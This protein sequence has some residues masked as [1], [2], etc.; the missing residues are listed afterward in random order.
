MEDMFVKEILQKASQI[1]TENKNEYVTVE[2]ILYT[3]VDYPDIAKVLKEVEVDK[4]K[5]KVDLSHFMKSKIPVVKERIKPIESVGVVKLFTYVMYLSQSLMK[6]VDTVLIFTALCSFKDTFAYYYLSKHGFSDEKVSKFTPALPAHRQ[7]YVVDMIE[8]AK[9][10]KYDKFIGR[11]KELSQ[12]MQTLAKVRKK[13]VLLVSEA[14]CGKTALIEGFAQMLAKGDVPDYLKNVGLYSLN[15]AAVVANTKM[16]G[17]L[18]ERINGI[19][20]EVVSRK[21]ILFIDELQAV[22]GANT[23]SNPFDISSVLKPYL[24]GGN[25]RCI[26][27]TTYEDYKSISKDRAFVRRFQKLELAE[28]TYDEALQILKGIV[29]AYE[30]HYSMKYDE[31]CLLSA[32]NLTQK[33]ITDRFLPDKAIDL[34]DEVGAD[35]FKNKRK[36]TVRVEDV[37]RVLSNM[38]RVPL[39]KVTTDDLD[40][41][42]NL[43][44]N[45]KEKIFGQDN[46]IDEVVKLIK[47]SK[48]GLTGKNKPIMSLV[49]AGTSGSG[50]TEL[51]RQLA[52]NLG[53]NLL[54]FDMSEY[55]EKHSVAK[56][57]GSPPGYVAYDEGG[58]LVSAVV[59]NPHSVIL[60]DEIEKADPSVYNILL[61]IMDYGFLTE[62]SGRKADFR[63][64]I[65]IMTTNAGSQELASGKAVIGFGNTE[66]KVPISE[67]EK[68]FSPEFRNRLDGIMFFNPITKELMLKVVD[69]FLAEF[70]ELVKAK[71]V[72]V[73]L[74]D[75]AKE[76]IADKSLE[77][78]LGARPALRYFS[79]LKGKLVDEILFLNGKKKTITVDE[80][81]GEFVYDSK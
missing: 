78:K 6:E 27:T 68:R 37:E 41:I 77:E 1:A 47:L 79:T 69:K 8:F 17:E 74:T 76:Y 64:C 40:A 3:L 5:I 80:R 29:P 42:K 59:K 19:I 31:E 43:S 22:V 67:I 66:V 60:L 58:M 32:I 36:K 20:T 75:K 38:I 4:D 30:K 44:H 34:L 24:T 48:A 13:N 62:N 72:T 16:R 33:Y 70:N 50:K 7:S 23:P 57:I 73:V 56:L 54:R 53:I 14:G 25:F 51:A 81:D 26:A 52:F 61:Q 9:Q 11:E 2:H 12:L 49:A 18:E 55:S 39:E 21:A 28:P 35:N 63:H 10:G 46:V 71:N 65:L 45:L 15:V